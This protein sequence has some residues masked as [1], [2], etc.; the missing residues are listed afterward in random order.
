MSAA[1]PKR[2]PKR[3]RDD[4][5]F[6]RA[7]G[8]DLSVLD[9]APPRLDVARGLERL[10]AVDPGGG[11]GGGGSSGSA[12]TGAGAGHLLV[13][14]AVSLA[15]ALGLAPS[16]PPTSDVAPPPALAATPAP[17]SASIVTNSPHVP[18]SPPRVARIDA[19][20]P[21][22]RHERRAPDTAAPRPPV[23]PSTVPPSTAA[24]K[25]PRKPVARH[26]EP[27]DRG[28]TLAAELASY[29]A[30]LALERAGDVTRAHT[31][32]ATHMTK[33]PDGALAAEVG[34][35]LARTALP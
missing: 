13:L 2:G 29:E 24:P 27:E 22:T 31:A 14:V 34:A 7:S 35:A 3:W 28:S 15:S 5:E 17:E 33:Y 26:P 20:T 16:R 6:V 19:T 9:D 1:D 12:A 8:I 25:P 23:P 21:P 10:R 30:A 18:N 32:F 11:G 4:A